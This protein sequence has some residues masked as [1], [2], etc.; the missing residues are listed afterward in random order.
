MFKQNRRDE[1]VLSSFQVQ[2]C[3]NFPRSERGDCSVGP[4]DMFAGPHSSA[5]LHERECCVP[6]AAPIVPQLARA[7]RFTRMYLRSVST[8][9]HAATSADTA[10]ATP[11]VPSR[12][13]ALRQHDVP[14]TPDVG[15][16]TIDNTLR[17]L[18]K[19]STPAADCAGPD[20][21]I[22]VPVFSVSAMRTARSRR[23]LANRSLN[24][25]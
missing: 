14:P 3:A 13:R 1:H 5:T 11:R 7:P 21:S 22:I 24:R 6:L 9:G 23:I 10:T 8:P 17:H 15:E 16:V 25:F 18:D 2:D 19:K 4:L 20:P 12:P